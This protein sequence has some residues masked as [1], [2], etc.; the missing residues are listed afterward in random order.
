[1]EKYE[2]VLALM[3]EKGGRLTVD[4][5]DLVTLLGRLAYRI[6]AYIT[7]IRTKAKLEVQTETVDRKVVAYRLVEVNPDATDDSR[8]QSSK[9]INGAA[10]RPVLTKKEA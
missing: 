2:R 8:W 3:K 1:M 6:S 10:P 7:F 5:P 9:Y 4:D